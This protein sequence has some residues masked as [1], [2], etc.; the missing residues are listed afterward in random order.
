MIHHSQVVLQALVERRNA[1]RRLEAENERFRLLCQQER[2]SRRNLVR[3]P[4]GR[5]VGWLSGAAVEQP[6]VDG[7]TVHPETAT[8]FQTAL[9]PQQGLGSAC[10][11][12]GH[13]CDDTSS[14]LSG[15]VCAY[16]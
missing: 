9:N 12:S 3:R 8:G 10:V 15:E 6:L 2:E 7:S 11:A 1:E 5:I 13:H 16:R 14:S 4:V